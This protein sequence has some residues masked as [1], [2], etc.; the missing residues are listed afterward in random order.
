MCCDIIS[1]GGFYRNM[2]NY[3]K[4]VQSPPPFGA[5]S[6][7]R[8]EMAAVLSALKSKANMEAYIDF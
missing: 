1:L 8:F 3:R 2:F 6:S 7:I 4:M 5:V